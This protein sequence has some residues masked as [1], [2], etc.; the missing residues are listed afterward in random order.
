MELC[1]FAK[2]FTPAT[3][4]CI[5]FFC[6]LCG[7]G[8][9]IAVSCPHYIGFY[10]IYLDLITNLSLNYEEICFNIDADAHVGARA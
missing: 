7:R 9:D 3:I 1:Q 5:D 8:N 4:I 6:Y 2:K 10:L